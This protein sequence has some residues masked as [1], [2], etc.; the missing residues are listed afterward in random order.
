MALTA[1]SWPCPLILSC[2]H[3]V[4]G[5]VCLGPWVTVS[6]G[7]L[8]PLSLRGPHSRAWAGPE[9]ACPCLDFTGWL[10]ATL[11]ALPF[12][13]M[14]LILFFGSSYSLC[15]NMNVRLLKEAVAPISNT[16][17]QMSSGKQVQPG[18]VTSFKTGCQSQA[19]TRAAQRYVEVVDFH[20]L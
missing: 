20:R 1:L 17:P 2:L 16:Y 15:W 5:H 13:S 8:R 11:T 18:R 7:P 3:R 9:A 19:K 12:P 14:D 6:R 10:W 4:H